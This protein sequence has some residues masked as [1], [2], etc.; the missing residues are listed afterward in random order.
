MSRSV[1]VHGHFYQPPRENPWTGEVDP[2]PSAAPFHDWNQRIDS[3]CYAPMAQA[4]VLGPNGEVQHR[5]NLYAR[6]SFDVGP[7]LFEWMET[8]APSTYASTL[9]ADRLSLEKLGHG[10]AI[11]MPYHHTILPL[12]SYRDKVTEVRWGIDDF[13]RRFKREPEGMWLPETAVD[14]ETLD[15][16]ADQGILFTILAPHQVDKISEQGLPLRFKGGSNREIAICIY[17]DKLSADIA[18]GRL[19]KDGALLASHL[20]PDDEKLIT[21]AAM[22]GETFGHHHHFGEMALARA[23]RVLEERGNV[24]IENFASFLARNPPQEDAVLVAPSSWSCP[25]GVERWRS[26]CGC[27]LA[28]EKHTSQ[29]WRAPLREGLEWLAGEL[30]EIFERDGEDLFIADPWLIRDQYG[31]V[32]S[33]PVAKA[34]EFIAGNISRRND[35]GRIERAAELLEMEDAALKMFTSCAWF[36]DDLARIETIQVLKYAAFAIE[37]SGDAERLEAGLLERIGDAKS[38]DPKEGTARHIWATHVMKE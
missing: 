19:I 38:N 32:V 17:D 21:A 29:E 15:V 14:E 24:Q 36:F 23:F 9:E 30:H 28:P 26:N 25:H 12:A 16:L 4:R 31:E 6:M 33:G 1:V 2:E 10:N 35:E 11:A 20:D 18:F 22:D 13:R 27:A 34:F 3:E 5:D 8:N 37:L 7:P